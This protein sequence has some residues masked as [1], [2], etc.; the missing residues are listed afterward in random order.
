[1]VG[2]EGVRLNGVTDHVPKTGPVGSRVAR[3]AA[4]AKE[5]AS[6]Y[7]LSNLRLF[8]SVARGEDSAD[9][10]IDLL[11]DVGPGVG[12][13]DLAGCERDLEEL[14]GAPVDLIPAQDL[15]PGLTPWALADATPL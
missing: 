13:F 5:I 1:M 15:K 8:G 6:R 10:D 12:L 11:V 9:S 2:A 4:E 3:H 7:G 14:L